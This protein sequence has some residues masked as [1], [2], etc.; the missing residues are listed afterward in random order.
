M[1]LRVISLIEVAA[2]KTPMARPTTRDTRSRGIDTSMV[3]ISASRARSTTAEESIV[4][5]FKGE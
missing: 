4:G 1:K 2:W 5:S 3:I